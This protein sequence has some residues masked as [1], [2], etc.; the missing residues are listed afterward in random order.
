M[1]NSGQ[2]G[3]KSRCDYT[4]ACKKC[5]EVYYTN[6]N[7]DQHKCGE[8]WCYRCNCKRSKTHHCIMPKAKK[9]ERKITRKRVY[10]D[11]EVGYT[12]SYKNFKEKLYCRA[13]LMKKRDNRFQ[14]CLLHFDAVRHAHR[15]YPKN[16]T[17][18][19]MKL[20]KNALRMEDWRSLKT[21]Q[22]KTKMSMWPQSVL[23]GYSLTIIKDMLLSHIMLPGKIN[24]THILKI[25]TESFRYDGQ[26]IF[27]LISAKI[28]KSK[29]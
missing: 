15:T 19:K 10:F 11:I 21:S 13:E 18:W 25:N 4:I 9:C 5:G 23:N 16:T 3:G 24:Q 7:K 28:E 8:K 14:F 1:C 17:L 29:F 12:V 22:Q 27:F 6:K 2:H 26:F 20:V